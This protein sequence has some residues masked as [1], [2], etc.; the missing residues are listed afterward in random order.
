MNRSRLFPF[1]FSKT[2][3]GENPPAYPEHQN[4]G[5]REVEGDGG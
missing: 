5:A 4:K 3:E 1:R 2:G